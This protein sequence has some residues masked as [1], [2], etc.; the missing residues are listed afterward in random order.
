MILLTALTILIL[1]LAYKQIDKIT[2][3]RKQQKFKR[4][5]A[6]REKNEII[7]LEELKTESPELYEKITKGCKSRYLH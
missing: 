5:E 7:W 6:E 3:V 4:Q 2:K 1:L